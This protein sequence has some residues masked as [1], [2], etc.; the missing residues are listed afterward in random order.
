MGL[1]FI[2]WFT[3]ALMAALGLYVTL[4]PPVTLRIKL[5]CWGGF[6]ALTFAGLVIAIYEQSQQDAKDKDQTDSYKNLQ[7]SNA[8]LASEIH[9]ATSKIDKIGEASGVTIKGGLN[10]KLDYL[11]SNLGPTKDAVANLSNIA[12]ADRDYH[13]VALLNLIG[14][15]GTDGDV[16][17]NT[18]I[19][20][21]MEGAYTIKGINVTFNTDASAEQKF[22]NV[23][24]LNPKFPFSYIALGNILRSRGDE[25]WKDCYLKAYF[26]LQ[27]TTLVPGHHINH[28]DFL[29]GLKQTFASAGIVPTPP[30]STPDKSASP[31]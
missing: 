14:K 20:L 22:R 5:W 3:G 24:A 19:S 13:E 4:H 25:G 16:I 7:D 10:D 30:L 9:D 18:P 27:K 17:Y 29:V 11:I 23:I 31:P 21:A 8:N 12:E 2:V 15:P 28:D 6:I 26:I 1:V